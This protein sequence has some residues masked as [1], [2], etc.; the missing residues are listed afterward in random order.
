MQK[1]LKLS[2]FLQL[3][4]DVLCIDEIKQIY[5]N[6]NLNIYPYFLFQKYLYFLLLKRNLLYNNLLIFKIMVIIDMV[7]IGYIFYYC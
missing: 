3:A 6:S 5:L 7:I 2:L 1:I 4:F